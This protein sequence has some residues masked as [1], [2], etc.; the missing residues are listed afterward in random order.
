M[1]VPDFTL[2]FDL[3]ITSTNERAFPP[4]IRVAVYI[5]KPN[6]KREWAILEKANFPVWDTSTTKYTHMEPKRNWWR[7]KEGGD[8]PKSS[9]VRVIIA[10]TAG[11]QNP[12]MY[13]QR[14]RDIVGRKKVIAEFSSGR[15]EQGRVNTGAKILDYKILVLEGG[16]VFDVPIA[17]FPQGNENN[18][19]WLAEW[20]KT[21]Q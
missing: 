1:I 18:F 10:G 6:G 12:V 2:S 9:D 14:A 3:I 17:T 11:T 8:G 19:E 7:V 16:A 21:T 13:E 20:R 4:M 5:E 15:S